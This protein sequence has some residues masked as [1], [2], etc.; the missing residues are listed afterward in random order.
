MIDSRTVGTSTRR[1]VGYTKQASRAG[2]FFCLSVCCVGPI[3]TQHRCRAGPITDKTVARQPE[4]NINHVN[5]IRDRVE[6][7]NIGRN[8]LFYTLTLLLAA[9]S[10]TRQSL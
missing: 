2:S 1:E 4:L 7:R 5:S 9:L 8:L 6:R 3:A 10:E